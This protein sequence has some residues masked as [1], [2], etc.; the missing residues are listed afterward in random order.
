MRAVNLQR[1]ATR[2]SM[3]V[4]WAVRFIHCPNNAF[5]LQVDFSYQLQLYMKLLQITLQIKICKMAA[6]VL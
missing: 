1:F 2:G 4:H 3:Q 6:R 5:D